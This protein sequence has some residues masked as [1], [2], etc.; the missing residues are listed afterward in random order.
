MPDFSRIIKVL[1]I[2]PHVSIDGVEV[3][4]DTIEPRSITLDQ[5]KKVRANSPGFRQLYPKLDN[6]TLIYAVEHNLA[7]CS[8]H[9]HD[10]CTYDGVLKKILVLELV[11][12]LRGANS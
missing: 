3:N 12:R 8:S 9:P 10:D 11:D 1:K 5:Y 4:I 7:N 6:E 2:V